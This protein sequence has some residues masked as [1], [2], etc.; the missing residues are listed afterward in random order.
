MNRTIFFQANKDTSKD[1]SKNSWRNS[2]DEGIPIEQGDLISVESVVIEDKNF[3]DTK[4]EISDEQGSNGIVGNKITVRIAPYINN[5]GNYCCGL[6]F[7]TTHLNNLPSTINTDYEFGQYPIGTFLTE[8]NI[9]TIQSVSNFKISGKKYF[10]VVSKNLFGERDYAAFPPALRMYNSIEPEQEID[11]TLI[12]LEVPSGYYT[13]AQLSS[14]LTEQMNYIYPDDASKDKYNRPFLNKE[15]I[16]NT[17]GNPIRAYPANLEYDDDTGIQSGDTKVYFGVYYNQPYRVMT[18]TRLLYATSLQALPSG[19]AFPVQRYSAITQAQTAPITKSDL[20]VL[21]DFSTMDVTEPN[22]NLIKYET[23][24][25]NLEYTDANLQIIKDFLG[26]ESSTELYNGSL[27]DSLDTANINTDK[28]SNFLD[29]G[30]TNDNRVD[31]TVT[32]TPIGYRG[33]KTD[34]GIGSIGSIPVFSRYSEKV[35]TKVKELFTNFSIEGHNYIMLPPKDSIWT[36][37]KEVNVALF[38]IVKESTYGTGSPL[39]LLSFISFDAFATDAAITV[40]NRIGFDFSFTRN[41]SIM[42][43][44]PD[45][46]DNFNVNF[47]NVG[48]NNPIIGYDANVNKCYFSQFHFPKFISNIEVVDSATDIK[49]VA[50]AGTE[51]IATQSYID[52]FKRAATPTVGTVEG[53][54]DQI[55]GFSIDDIIVYDN[56]NSYSIK[57]DTENKLWDNNLLQRLGFDKNDIFTKYGLFNNRH[58]TQ[59]WNNFKNRDFGNSMRLLSTGALFDSALSTG[60]NAKY[61]SEAAISLPI[62]MNGFSND[63]NL[64]ITAVSLKIFAT[65]VPGGLIFPLYLINSTI[66]PNI[67]YFNESG[68]TNTIYVLNRSYSS[69]SMI[70]G[71]ANNNQYVATKSFTLTDILTTVQYPDG[72]TPGNL[73]EKCL[74]VYKITKPYRMNSAINRSLLIENVQ[75][76]RMDKKLLG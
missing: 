7:S 9:S 20:V 29:L 36:K 26:K 68:K 16:I 12:D 50:D 48:A 52:N 8:T 28:W 55:T 51:I 57:D 64:Q 27:T 70:Y 53:V 73:G 30:I 23:I 5:V 34:G 49:P 14:L 61:F 74:I 60:I 62:F 47:I 6:P 76:G 42:A 4:I 59:T 37:I 17:N 75:D 24:A 69:G 39:I 71:A 22:Q 45:T 72:S 56:L 3:G 13:P 58:N 21:K 31:S 46:A 41:D 67:E 33:Y 15:D 43:M 1:K 32:P 2:V 11:T 35:I 66:L 19:N 63:G 54:V 10:R 38:P 18:G 40:G 44:N 25:T 65:D